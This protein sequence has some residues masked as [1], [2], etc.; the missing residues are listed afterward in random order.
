MRRRVLRRY[1]ACWPVSLSGRSGFAQEGHPLTGTWGGDWGPSATQ[2]NHLTFVM[3]WDG[4]KVTGTHQPGP[5]RHSAR[6]RG[7]GRDELDR[8]YRGRCQ[9]RFRKTGPG[10]R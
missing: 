3:N 7:P 4:D 10:H 8:S 1:C 9:G 5:G 2:R 6:E